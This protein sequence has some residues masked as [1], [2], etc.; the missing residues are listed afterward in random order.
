MPMIPLQL[1]QMCFANVPRVWTLSQISFLFA[2]GKHFIIPSNSPRFPRI[3]P[4]VLLDISVFT[5]VLVKL[6]Y[7]KAA[8]RGVQV[9]SILDVVSKDGGIYFGFIASSHFLVVVMY[10]V[11]RV[12][13]IARA[14]GFNAC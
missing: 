4:P 11:A 3:D 8:H 14:L 2:F 6:Y 1:Y 5:L 12:G 9:Q 13:F 10:S 7:M